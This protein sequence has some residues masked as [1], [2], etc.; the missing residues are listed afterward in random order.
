L[1]FRDLRGGQ[2]EKSAPRMTKVSGHQRP[3][4][5]A[6]RRDARYTPAV[7]FA[8]E[9]SVS[10]AAERVSRFVHRGLWR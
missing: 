5:D 1:A 4:R 10:W 2:D 8:A 7:E 3:P 6:S 9:G